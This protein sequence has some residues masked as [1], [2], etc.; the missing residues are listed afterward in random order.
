MFKF[1]HVQIQTD[2][3]K[4]PEII[5]QLFASNINA[6]KTCCKIHFH[7]PRFLEKKCLVQWRQCISASS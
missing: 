7:W 1:E 5:S 3:V 6:G 4:L 2:T